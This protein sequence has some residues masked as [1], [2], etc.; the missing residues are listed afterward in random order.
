ME[1]L[2][3]D[4]KIYI[5]TADQNGYTGLGLI[6]AFTRH[7]HQNEIYEIKTFFSPIDSYTN[8]DIFLILFPSP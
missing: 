1:I 4:K 2:Y 5:P 7:D 6:T 3:L 8:G